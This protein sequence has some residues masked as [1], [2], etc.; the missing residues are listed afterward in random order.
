MIEEFWQEYLS[1]NNLDKNLN[2]DTVIKFDDDKIKLI[3]ENEKTAC[4]SA[5]SLYEN[6]DEIT[7]DGKLAIVLDSKDE[8]VCVIKFLKTRITLFKNINYDLAKLEGE[9][10]NLISWQKNHIEYFT[11]EL[12]KNNLKF[13]Y[14]MPLVFDEFELLYKKD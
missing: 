9:D 10:K 11:K 5:L 6:K 14:D 8:A 1:K 13:D 7:K 12:E 4:S 2:Y 3:L